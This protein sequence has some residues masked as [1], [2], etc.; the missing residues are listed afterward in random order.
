MTNTLNIMPIQIY[1]G[2]QKDRWGRVLPPLPTKP[3]ISVREEYRRRTTLRLK[4]HNDSPMAGDVSLE[5]RIVRCV[6]VSHGPPAGSQ[7][8]VCRV[9]K[10][11]GD[12]IGNDVFL[13]VFDPLHVALDDLLIDFTSN[14]ISCC[15]YL[16][17]PTP[18]PR[19]RDPLGVT[20]HRCKSLAQTLVNFVA[21]H[22]TITM[23]RQTA[24]IL[25]PHLRLKNPIPHCRIAPPRRL[26]TI[27]RNVSTAPRNKIP[28]G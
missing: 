4:P 5:V 13:L 1:P 6:S 2:A 3:Y 28:S 19:G 7:K 16:L 8:L 24:A 12:L 15:S 27:N 21:F 10:G 22:P 9:V 14:P 23:H 11:P 25:C 20:R 26:K 17:E 18:P